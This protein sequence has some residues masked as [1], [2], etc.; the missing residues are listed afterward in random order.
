[1]ASKF[2]DLCTL[3]VERAESGLSNGTQTYG[4]NPEFDSSALT[5]YDKLAANFVEAKPATADEIINV[6]ASNS[7]E[8]D[9]KQ[10]AQAVFT[11]LI[12]SNVLIPAAASEEEASEGEPAAAELEKE[13]EV[14]VE[15]PAV[16]VAQ[17]A[18]EEEGQEEKDEGSALPP[19]EE[20]EA[21]TDQALGMKNRV[22]DVSPEADSDE[23]D[24]DDDTPA[25]VLLKREKEKT[26][27]LKQQKA[28][29]VR[30]LF[31]KR[32][33]SP[34]EAEQYISHLAAKGLAA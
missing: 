32:G 10:A 20:D 2:D 17:V 9:N 26:E 6:I 25:S 19:P 24:E 15:E 22:Q 29:L 18:G 4:L 3:V 14:A 23:G 30:Y 1:M 33:K 34:E 31:K 8:P 21:A 28:N 12:D 27:R 7:D 5:G 16:A 13:P 11:N